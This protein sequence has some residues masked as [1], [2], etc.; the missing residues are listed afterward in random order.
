MTAAGIKQ[1]EI[2]ACIGKEGLSDAT[3]RKYF[4]RELKI[5]VSQVHGLCVAGIVRAMQKGQAWA[6]CF[7]AKTRMGWREKSAL[8]DV[9]EIVVKRLVGVA[10]EDV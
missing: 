9:S 2:A 10:I 5:G 1:D 3:L 4:A 7:Y 8:D 6:L